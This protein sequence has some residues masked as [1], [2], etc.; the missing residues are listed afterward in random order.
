MVGSEVRREFM[1]Q[2]A[3]IC[4]LCPTSGWVII[5]ANACPDK[6]EMGGNN[7]LSYI[8]HVAPLFAKPAAGTMTYSHLTE[9]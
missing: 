1:R 5:H 7:P 3:S 8:S 2:S 9:E 6:T 4:L